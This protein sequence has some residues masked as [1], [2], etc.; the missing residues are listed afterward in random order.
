M[1]I[2][3]KQECAPLMP[4]YN[5]LN[6]L[7]NS[8]N[9]GQP[10]FKYVC[11]VYVNGG[12]TYVDRLMVPPHP[13]YG[14]GL[15]NPA[16]IIENY[17]TKDID[18]TTYGF[19]ANSN[20]Y[21]SY[22]LKFGES[23]GASSSGATVYPNQTVTGT[24]YVWNA[25]YDFEDWVGYSSGTINAGTTSCKF[26]TN[27]PSSGDIEFTDNAYLY[28]NSI[29]SGTIDYAYIVT[30]D[31]S[32]VTINTAKVNNPYK[33]TDKF[34]RFCSSPNLINQ[35]LPANI[36]LGGQPIINSTDYAYTI[37]MFNASNVAV[38]EQY[39]F[40]IASPCT[41]YD[42]YR[43]H[44]LN[45]L[46]GY[47]AFT[48]SKVNRFTSDVKRENYKQNL[49]AYAALYN[50]G[51]NVS[52]RAS[53]QYDTKITDSVTC[54]SDWVTE[55]QMV[56][57]EELITSPDVYVEKNGSLV[58]INITTGKHERKKQVNDKLFNLTIEFT[59]SYTRYRQRF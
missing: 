29:T 48:F 21:A 43:I 5:E 11:D 46:G 42:K 18:L 45:K 15:F 38:T 56:W 35:I 3:I 19:G 58:P 59:Y 8:S 14:T 10:N 9:Y 2:Q 33:A 25:V 28:V 54:Q 36:T 1:A 34:F 37:Q 26:L 7:V 44:F 55:A 30:K 50:Y 52:Q 4:A 20:S 39:R 53:T 49:G 24:K 6:H 51:Y 22:I 31:S 27:R 32:N 57:L 23:Y 17:L 47:D 13:S 12:A 16:R 41:K 40:T